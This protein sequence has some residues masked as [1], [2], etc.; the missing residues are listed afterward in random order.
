MD[1]AL[2]VTRRFLLRSTVG[3]VAGLGLSA[4]AAVRGAEF[5][6]NGWATASPASVGLGL[7]GLQEAQ[8]FAEQYGGAGCVIRHGRVAHVWG[9][10]DERYQVQ[11]T[12]KSW[13]SAVLGMA[14][15][16]GRLALGDRARDHLPDLGAIPASNLETGWLDGIT[17]D[18]LATHTSGF[19]FPSG[20]SELE[21]APGTRWIYSN[22]GSNWLSNVLTRSFGQD[23]REL[24]RT[25]LFGPLGLTDD[26]VRWRTPAIFFKEPVDGLPATEFNGGMLANVD[27][28]ARL[29][30]LF[31]HGGNWDGKQVLSR[32]F[33]ELA[34]TPSY[35]RQPFRTTRRYGL[36][37]WSNVTGR[38]PD[39][40]PDAFYS[41]GKN[42][43]HT[44]VIPS[45]DM[46]VVR[47]GNEGWT[48]DG[49]KLVSFLQPIV[50]AAY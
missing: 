45:L 48:E 43:N 11:S 5:P 46:I 25:R 50:D 31:L 16:E 42:A 30:M 27:A 47:V 9:S 28:M 24:T 22:C 36:L 49:G 41:A 7:A 34:T 13:G 10:F 4:P 40:P 35:A 12:T 23:L 29:G 37:W 20:Y 3:A 1:Q 8:R 6:T 33:I 39:V 17:I 15:D 38:M 19:P 2:P 32:S 26:D 21:T 44:I 14:L 18:H